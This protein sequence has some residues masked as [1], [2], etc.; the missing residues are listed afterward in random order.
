MT[1][2]PHPNP[3]AIGLLFAPGAAHAHLVTSGLGPFYDGALHL[4]LSPGDLLGLIVLAL[5][6]GLRG[7]AAARPTLIAVTLC[8]LLAGMLGLHVGFS[9]DLAWPGLLSVVVLGALVAADIRLPPYVVASLGGL[10]GTLHGLI[11]GA[12]LADL[13]AG[14]TS[15]LGTVTTVLVLVLLTSAGIVPL[16]AFWARV[17]VRIAGS[18]ILAVSVLMLGWWVQ[19]AA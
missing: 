16:R 2:L 11:N 10:F 8:W 9:V 15:L 4:L 3:L 14:V 5:L 17:G 1:R 7:S 13:G 12:L 19:G 18:W 6:A